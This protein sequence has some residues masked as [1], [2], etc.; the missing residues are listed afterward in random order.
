VGHAI[1]RTVDWP[2]PTSRKPLALRDAPLLDEAHRVWIRVVADATRDSPSPA[3]RRGRTLPYGFSSWL[4]QLRHYG[5]PR[6]G[7]AH[8]LRAILASRGHTGKHS[9]R[10]T[11]LGR[12]GALRCASALD[13]RR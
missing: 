9:N 13:A 3:S 4:S 7:I 2:F 12:L 5:L 8:S 10:G 11:L 6:I 1:V